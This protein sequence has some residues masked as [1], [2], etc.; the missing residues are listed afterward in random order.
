MG[1]Y[2]DAGVGNGRQAQ[3]AGPRDGKVPAEAVL[4]EP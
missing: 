2:W 3:G 4:W 1:Y